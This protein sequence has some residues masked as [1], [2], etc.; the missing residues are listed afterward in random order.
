M[1]KIRFIA[2][3]VLTLTLVLILASCGGPEKFY[4][5]EY[6]GSAEVVNSVKEL[7]ELE[8]YG[9]FYKRYQ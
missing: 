2:L 9:I 7:V 3:A 1:K 8:G 6:T 5:M 4:N